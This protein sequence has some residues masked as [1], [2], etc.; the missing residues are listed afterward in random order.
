[1]T[2]SPQYQLSRTHLRRA[3]RKH[4]QLAYRALKSKLQE[5]LTPI[6][7]AITAANLEEF[8]AELYGHTFL[9]DRLRPDTKSITCNYCGVWSPLP[10]TAAVGAAIQAD[11]TVEFYSGAD[12]YGDLGIQARKW[13]ALAKLET[14][15]KVRTCSAFHALV[16]HV[17]HSQD[18]SGITVVQTEHAEGVSAS[19]I[20][21][22]STTRASIPTTA[23]ADP[24][25]PSAV[26]AQVE[27]YARGGQ[28]AVIETFFSY[29]DL[30]AAVCVSWI[31]CQAAQPLLARAVV[32]NGGQ[33]EFLPAHVPHGHIPPDGREPMSKVSAETLK[34]Q[35]IHAQ[36]SSAAPCEIAPFAYQLPALF[37]PVRPEPTS[38]HAHG[39]PAAECKQ[40]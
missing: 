18:T 24:T 23:R 26:T 17:P 39:S 9:Q 16:E 4:T 36:S 31:S 30:G 25:L 6:P 28:N 21:H 14:L 38:A 13:V 19:P 34:A 1:M 8:R 3:N 12:D 27:N 2:F 5:V 7:A 37:Q 22:A 40:Q 35:H 20:T 10:P 11:H 29:P 32:A 15:A 33:A